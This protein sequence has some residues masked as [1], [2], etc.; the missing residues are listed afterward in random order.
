VA[1][2][3]V[4]AS[5]AGHTR[6]FED[7]GAIFTGGAGVRYRLA[8]KLGLDAGLDV[9]YGPQGAVFYIQFGHAWGLRMD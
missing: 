5:D 8:R 1:F 7:S 9:A 4:G 3:G 2:G 6:L